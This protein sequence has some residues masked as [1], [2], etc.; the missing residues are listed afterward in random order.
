MIKRNF[1][2]TILALSILFTTTILFGCSNTV[3]VATVETNGI[4][5]S[6][7]QTIPL[8]NL[9]REA[10]NLGFTCTG[11]TYSN[12]NNSFYICNF[13]QML[14]SS[15][16]NS[17]SIVQLSTD[18]T[19]VLSEITLDTF[20]PKT[21]SL[22]GITYDNSNDSL[23]FADYADNAI[24]NI[25]TNGELLSKI[26]YSHANGIAYDSKSDTLWVINNS[27][28]KGNVIIQN[29][30]KSGE[31]VVTISISGIYH[32]DQLF[33]DEKNNILYFSA[34]ANYVGEN[35]VY[36]ISLTEY[37]CSQKFTLTDSYAIE[38][39]YIINNDL[40]VCNDGYYHSSYSNTNEIKVYQISE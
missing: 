30:K 32:S 14:P 4:A 26:E 33:L 9:K 21:A 31:E 27:S 34:G 5:M 19:T 8:P 35:Y 37:S 18:Y 10:T 15:E 20:L 23:W 13:G 16:N 6:A 38:G 29:I 39:I 17:P 24:Y 28:D 1:V 36:E 25:T 2:L 40:I 11:L 22:Q 7:K 12:V 3:I